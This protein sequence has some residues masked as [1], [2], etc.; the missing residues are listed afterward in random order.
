M[1][2]NTVDVYPDEITFDGVV[3]EGQMRLHAHLHT[4]LKLNSNDILAINLQLEQLKK[5]HSTI[6]DYLEKHKNK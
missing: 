3:S 4:N 2:K 6:G 5:L 1:T